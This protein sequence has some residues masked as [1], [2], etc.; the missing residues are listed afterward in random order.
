MKNFDELFNLFNVKIEDKIENAIEQTKM[1]LNN[2]TINRTCM[3]YSSYLYNNLK[4]QLVN[5]K[6]MDTAEDL[7]INYRHR[8]VTVYENGKTYLIDLTFSQFGNEDLLLNNLIEKGY[9]L[10]D[11]KKWQYYI[12]K[13][14]MCTEK[15]KRK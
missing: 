14:L 9:E 7:K 2:L 15:K 12:G 10:M 4:Q 11:E 13:I 5:C 6:I 8:F 1:Q 3:I